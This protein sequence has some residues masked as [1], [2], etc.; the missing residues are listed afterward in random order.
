[1]ANMCQLVLDTIENPD[2]MH[3]FYKDDSV[4]IQNQRI[5][6]LVDLYLNMPDKGVTTNSALC[7][8]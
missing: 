4:D 1:M 8:L 6:T 2:F 5:T 3:L 7:N